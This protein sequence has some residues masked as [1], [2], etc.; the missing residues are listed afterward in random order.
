MKIRQSYSRREFF[1]TTGGALILLTVV[2]HLPSDVASAS[3]NTNAPQRV[4]PSSP[5][6]QR[7]LD[8]MEA[9][10]HRFWSVPRKDGEFL[11]FMVKA[12]RSRNVLEVGTSQ[13]F[14][15]I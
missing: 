1:K 11:H 14:S 15:A 12:T 9:R 3:G 5:N 10:G 6:I 8:E 13:G 2:A 4:K 7:L